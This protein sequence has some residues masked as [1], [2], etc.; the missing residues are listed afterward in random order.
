MTQADVIRFPLTYA[1]DRPV[2]ASCPYP[3][4]K[5]L[6]GIVSGAVMLNASALTH[7]TIAI[8]RGRKR[9]TKRVTGYE[10]VRVGDTVTLYTQRG[11]DLVIDVDRVRYA[12][13]YVAVLEGVMS[14]YEL[15][16]SY[17][18]FYGRAFEVTAIRVDDPDLDNSF[19]HRLVMTNADWWDVVCVDVNVGGTDMR[20]YDY[21]TQTD[22]ATPLT[23]TTNVMR[24]EA[25]S[26]VFVGAVTPGD[27]ETRTLVLAGRADWS[28]V[29]TDVLRI[30]YVP[31]P[32]YDAVVAYTERRIARMRNR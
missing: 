25:G 29:A 20:I 27:A 1:A 3:Q 6:L 12:S 24:I 26:H 19:R 15:P 13:Q 22:I 17:Y 14:I 9:K 11:S 8:E 10:D 7:Y 32:L 23:L 2:S 21:D 16:S 5:A 18:R 28:D 30:D 4:T 31:Q